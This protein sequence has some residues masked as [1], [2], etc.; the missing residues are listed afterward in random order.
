MTSN[1]ERATTLILALRSAVE[2]DLSALRNLLTDDVRAWTPALATSSRD[3]LL[4]E[5]DGRDGTFDDIAVTFNPLDVGGE[6][7]GVEWT[8]EMTHAGAITLDETT[9]IEPT[10]LRITLHGVTIAE[11]ADDRICSLRQYWDEMEI[12]EQLGVVNRHEVRGER[13]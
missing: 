4:A 2:R 10:G 1:Q 8:V 9:T 12:L 13:D 11:F 5:L 6:F 7:A 3:E